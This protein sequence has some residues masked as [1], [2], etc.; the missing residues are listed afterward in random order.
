MR[1]RCRTYNSML[2][3]LGKVPTLIL[4]SSIQCHKRVTV[5]HGKQQ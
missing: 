4:K 5:D 3:L 1:D 2:K